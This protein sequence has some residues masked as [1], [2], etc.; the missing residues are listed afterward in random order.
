MKRAQLSF[1]FLVY[2]A[3]AGL[4][5]AFIISIL[6]AGEAKAHFETNAYLLSNIAYKI[7]LAM[8]EGMPSTVLQLEI[9]E[10]ICNNSTVT[11][12]ALSAPYG[13]F[14]LIAPLKIEKGALCTPS[15]NASIEVLDNLGSFTLEKV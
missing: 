8:M 6:G 9:P 12:S 4:S 2:L 3:L 13:T 14:G 15:G 7:N 5:L 1:E 11:V 10:G